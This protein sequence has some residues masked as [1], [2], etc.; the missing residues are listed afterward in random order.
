MARPKS[1]FKKM[2]SVKKPTRKVDAFTRSQMGAEPVGPIDSLSK[3]IR[4]YSW[5]SGLHDRTQSKEWLIEYTKINFPKKSNIIALVEE[6]SLEISMGW[7]ARMLIKGL[8]LPDGL[9][10][11]LDRYINA[12]T[13]TKKYSTTPRKE[14]ADKISQ[15]LPDFE[16]AID[17]LDKT[18]DTYNYLTSN[19]V[20]QAYAV[21]ISE[22]YSPLVEELTHA[23]DKTDTQCVEA[24]STYKKSD[25]LIAR[26]Y[27]ESIVADCQRFVGN[28]KKER[29][30]RKT[31]KKSPAQRL[32]YFKF[33]ASHDQM[34]LTS[35]NP[36]SIFGASQLFTLNT[37]NY[38]LTMFV[39]KEGGFDINRTSIVN[40]DEDKSGAKRAGRKLKAVI[41]AVLNGN[42]KQRNDVLNMLDSAFVPF[43]DRINNNVVILKVVK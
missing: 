17:K 9:S 31:K 41:E 40:Y 10:A 30:P 12:Q 43:S 8:I 7:I 1:E 33:M 19:S 22:Y 25:I 15:Y 23:Y 24:Y 16:D 38:V 34:K 35:S 3:L 11:R 39:A 37:S 2:I 27:I 6:K 26:R 13:A 4:A 5:Y 20:P 28:V 42:K 14:S 32:K 21:R 36:E 18:F 29:A